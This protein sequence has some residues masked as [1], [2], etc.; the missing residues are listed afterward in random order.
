MKKALSLF[1][2]MVTIQLDAHSGGTDKYGCHAGSR[3]YHCHNPKTKPPSSDSTPPRRRP[4]PTPS[5][6]PIPPRSHNVDKSII[7]E[8]GRICRRAVEL[9][10]DELGG[11]VYDWGQ[12]RTW[13]RRT[14]YYFMQY[15]S[16]QRYS[17]TIRPMR[18]TC[19]YDT[20]TQT[21]GEAIVEDM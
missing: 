19:S 4:D 13:K 8:L 20:R 1:S 10:A 11:I 2:L 14:V 16:V 3:P 18:I 5:K 7:Y 9:R 21:L 6:R 15:F 12:R 17:G